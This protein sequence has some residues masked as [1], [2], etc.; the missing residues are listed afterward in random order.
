[1][2]IGQNLVPS[3]AVIY[4]VL[5]PS[6]LSLPRKL[7]TR[8]LFLSPDDDDDPQLNSRCCAVS[9][10]FVV[11]CY[12]AICRRVYGDVI[13]LLVICL[14]NFVSWLADC[15]RTG[16]AYGVYRLRQIGSAYDFQLHLFSAVTVWRPA[17]S[18]LQV[19]R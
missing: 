2:S 15:G 18:P 13:P 3:A 1:M 5:A 4:S 12:F 6:R 16:V 19:S 9:G 11:S 10:V 14:F 7:A 17:S 8:L